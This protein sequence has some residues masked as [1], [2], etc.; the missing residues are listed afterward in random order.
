MRCAQAAKVDKKDLDM[1]LLVGKCEEKRAE[2]AAAS[3]AGG[4]G[5]A[6]W[7]LAQQTYSKALKLDPDSNGEAAKGLKRATEGMAGGA[8]AAAAAA[9]PVQEEEPAEEEKPAKASAEKAA[10]AV[11]QAA[12][13]AGFEWGNTY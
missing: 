8:P 2:M 1:L 4:G 3:A 10:A 6:E 13:P 9:A 12:A 11:P 5:K 7:Y